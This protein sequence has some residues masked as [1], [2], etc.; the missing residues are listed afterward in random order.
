MTSA[1]VGDR[2]MVD[3]HKVDEPPRMVTI[4][5]FV[6]HEY[7]TS[8]RVAWDDGHESTFRP[9]AGTI[10]TVHPAEEKAG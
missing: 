6:E 4:L 1:T 2:I 10:H 8:F 9:T 3:S 7:G 5:E